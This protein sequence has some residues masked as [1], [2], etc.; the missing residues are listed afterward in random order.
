[1]TNFETIL[2]IGPNEEELFDKDI[3]LPFSNGIA[4]LV[5]QSGDGDNVTISISGDISNVKVNGEDFDNA[6]YIR[7]PIKGDDINEIEVSAGERFFINISLSDGNNHTCYFYDTTEEL[8]LRTGRNVD[9][10]SSKG[11]YSEISFQSNVSVE[12]GEVENIPDWCFVNLDYENNV[13]KINC[14][15]N[16]EEEERGFSFLLKSKGDLFERIS[17][18]QERY[19]HEDYFEYTFTNNSFSPIRVN[20]IL[21][22]PHQSTTV[23]KELDDETINFN[24]GL[25]NGQLEIRDANDNILFLTE[26]ETFSIRHRDLF[27]DGQ[28]YFLFNKNEVR[29]EIFNNSMDY[30]LILSNEETGEEQ[31][32]DPES[33]VVILCADLDVYTIS[34]PTATLYFN[35]SDIDN[36]KIEEGFLTN[37]RTY[38]FYPQKGL[39]WLNIEDAEDRMNNFAIQAPEA[40]DLAVSED[41][42]GDEVTI[43]RGQLKEYS[44]PVDST[45]YI[46]VKEYN[47]FGFDVVNTDT[48]IAILENLYSKDGSPI[49][50]NPSSVG[51]SGYDTFLID[52]YKA[53]HRIIYNFKGEFCSLDG[54]E[55]SVLIKPEGATA[56]KNLTL[57]GS[58]FAVSYSD[59][60]SI[61]DPIRKSTASAEFV[62]SDYLFEVYSQK[63]T[64]TQLIL[65]DEGGVVW[66]GYLKPTLLNQGY[67]KFI[68][69]ITLEGSDCIAALQYL[70]Y[71]PDGEKKVISFHDILAQICNRTSLNGFAYST[72]KTI[73]NEII[74]FKQLTISEQNFFDDASNKKDKE[75]N[76]EPW[77]LSEVL[78]EMCKYFGYTAVQI[79]DL[80]YLTDYNNLKNNDYFT[81]KLFSKSDNYTNYSLIEKGNK[82]TIVSKDYM[83]SSNDISFDTIYNKIKVN[84]N[85]SEIETVIPEIFDEDRITYRLGTSNKAIQK[86]VPKGAEDAPFYCTNSTRHHDEDDRKY[87]YYE[88]LLDNVDFES[89]YYLPKIVWESKYP[90]PPSVAFPE[91]N[92]FTEI[93][94]T[95]EELKSEVC[96]R[97]YIGATLIDLATIE[98]YKYDDFY[99]MSKWP[100]ANLDFK[101]Y[102]CINVNNYG[103][104]TEVIKQCPVFKLKP[105]KT[106]PFIFP[107]NEKMY[108]VVSGNML[109]TRYFKRDYI[110]KDWKDDVSGK[111]NGEAVVNPFIP[112]MSLRLGINGNYYSNIYGDYGKWTD[113]PTSIFYIPTVYDFDPRAGNAER[114]SFKDINKDEKIANNLKWEEWTGKEGFAIP[115]DSELDFNGPLDFAV[116]LPSNIVRVYSRSTSNNDGINGYAWISGLKIELAIEGANNEEY[117]S[118][119]V[120]ENVIDEESINEISDIDLKISTMPGS[121]V[122][123]YSHVAYNGNFLTEIDGKKPEE[124]I[125]EKYYKQYSTTTLKLNLELN[126]EF[127][128]FDKIHDSFVASDFAVIGTEIDFRRGSQTLTLEE[129]KPEDK[130][131]PILLEQNTVPA[132]GR[133]V[134]KGVVNKTSRTK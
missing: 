101:R 75:Q 7:I 126:N 134:I 97:S 28:P 117:K 45:L 19:E 42:T 10:F 96:S 68:E 125:V 66:Q 90:A 13:I 24:N 76:E 35:I 65:E 59:T 8:Y 92:L 48:G 17:V 49:V 94:L 132:Q 95:D 129:I 3:E 52:V 61:F 79:G 109:W 124:N 25:P 1:M 6:S 2:Y 37:N 88:R 91:E 57:G 16:T 20:D 9:T 54:H 34:T 58:P 72:N 78:E 60:D 82:K 4:R 122:L 128:Q 107:K 133:Q 118:D 23:R 108:L 99:Y 83:G 103:L 110:N 32:I 98:L 63:A 93:E 77:K 27:T 102:L 120:Y 22:Q 43:A 71:E 85:L 105:S 29:M 30:S 41:F 86:K 40:Y 89:T 115:L 127:T 38:S 87:L 33:T 104:N 55:Y 123:S 62:S 81:F 15:P 12:L 100:K 121:K 44:L 67:A 14:E 113:D 130:I 53:D 111:G 64:G 5:F 116:M 73:D 47:E 114:A 11:G 106:K 112:Y 50:I 119:L 131:T 56:T 39:F 46:K 70:E 36:R 18:N 84:V 26:E 74:D 21:L 69:T 31:S 80:L 51:M